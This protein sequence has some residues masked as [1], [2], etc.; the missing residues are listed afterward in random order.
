MLILIAESKTMTPC[1]N[2]VSKADYTDCRPMLESDADAIMETVRS[3]SADELVAT[4]K[5]SLPMVRKLQKMAYEFPN[6]A[7][8]SRAIEAFTGVVFKAFDYALLDEEARRNTAGCVRLLSSLYGWLRP[9]DIVKAYRM[10]FTTPLA[11]GGKAL[12][13]YWRDKVT[14][15]LLKEIA[16][17][18][19]ED[20]LNLLPGD[21]AKSIDWKAVGKSAKV[22]KAD[23]RELLPG[24]TTRTPNSGKLKTL[25]GELLRL[26]VTSGI[27]S[28][29]GLLSLHGEHFVSADTASS[30][31]NIEFHTIG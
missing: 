7:V 25:R 14:E 20:V 16:T 18:G 31:G 13:T 6:K 30:D 22:W 24:G 15:C 27:N 4:V 5:I 11:P 12:A 17:G 9:D 10:D 3:L 28:A 8:G 29:S 19:H 26:I 23:F 2:A 21:A 1:G